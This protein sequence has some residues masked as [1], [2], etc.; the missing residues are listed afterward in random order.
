MWE[1]RS[2]PGRSGRSPRRRSAAERHALMNDTNNAM[3]FGGGGEGGVEVTEVTSH[4]PPCPRPARRALA[5]ARRAGHRRATTLCTGPAAQRVVPD[6]I[7]YT[8]IPLNWVRAEPGGDRRGL[9][10]DMRVWLA[11]KWEGGKRRRRRTIFR[12]ASLPRL[13]AS[14]GQPW[15]G[16]TPRAEPRQSLPGARCTHADLPAP[17]AISCH[18][19]TTV[20]AT[21]TT[22]ARRTYGS[23]AL[24]GEAEEREIDD[25][26]WRTSSGKCELRRGD[27]GDTGMI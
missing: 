18:L 2:D 1:R 24:P 12:S 13:A 25:I 8:C 15:V 22:S 16:Q 6:P 21:A 3:R 23:R 5:T 26:A 17:S 11:V 20:W 10:L 19:S 14:L 7:E 27:T 9:R 4:A